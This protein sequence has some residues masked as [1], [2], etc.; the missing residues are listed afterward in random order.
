MKVY[1]KVLTSG[2][3]AVYQK[4]RFHMFYIK[5]SPYLVYVFFINMRLRNGIKIDKPAIELKKVLNND[6]P[7]NGNDNDN[8]NDNGNGMT[9]VF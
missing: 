4:D 1:T 8:D 5:A 9:L 3:W 6:E 7:S 2:L